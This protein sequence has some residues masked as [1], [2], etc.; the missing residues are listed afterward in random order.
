MNKIYKQEPEYTGSTLDDCLKSDQVVDLL[1]N[2]ITLEEDFS[3][4][5][6]EMLRIIGENAGVDRCYVYEYSDGDYNHRRKIF[7][8]INPETE[9][10]KSPL[11]EKSLSHFPEC[12]RIL[13]ERKPVIIED[14]GQPPSNFSP[15]E[16]AEFRNRGIQSV[17]L[18]G[19]W[20]SS[21]L[22]GFVGLDC[23]I[24]PQK[25]SRS[26]LHTVNCFANLFRL[27]HERTTQKEALLES[28]SLQ[29]QIMDN[30]SVP[31]LLLDLNYHVLAANP[32]KKVNVD[33]PL[34]QLLGT[35]CYNTVCKFGAPP[36]FC[37]VQETMRTKKPSSK[38]FSF[39]PKR[40]IS[41]A[42]PIFDR[43][44]EMQ[45]VLNIDLDITEVTRQKEELKAA[46]EQAQA[47]NHAKSYFLATVSHELRTPLNAV[48]GFTEL[49]QNGGIDE[50]TQEDYL[51]SINFA[52]NAL[53]NLINDVLDLSNL[54]ANQIL[55]APVKNDVAELITRVASVFK[56]KVKEKNIGLFTEVNEVKYPLYVDNLRLRQILLN[57]LGN[58][59]KF[60]SEGKV[61]V[62]ASFK[63]EDDEYGILTIS[64]TDTGI[65]I[66][67]ANQE[68]I[69]EPFVHDSVIRGKSMYEGSGLG[70]TISK[71]LLDKMGGSIHLDSEL[72]KGSTFTI[73]LNQVKYDP[74]ELSAAPREKPKS[75]ADATL[76]KRRML[77]VDDV[78]LN[79]KVLS[80]ML[81]L[82][83][84]E[85][86]LV[87]LPETVPDL[88]RQDNKYD[89]IL[90]DMWM[91]KLSGSELTE[92]IRAEKLTDIPIAA[93]TADTQISE[94]DR[95]LF[96]YILYKPITV[97]SLKQMLRT[98]FPDDPVK[99]ISNENN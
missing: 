92:Q 85:T 6:G 50:K 90:T 20:S 59:I 54:E 55:I 64:V 93:V 72:G 69:F 36:E 65:G 17:L 96:S 74:I 95:N 21:H 84:V 35:C 76:P 61:T 77:L 71:R 48:I 22:Y 40:L 91:P 75:L 45:Y 14:L 16:V 94:K 15:E 18:H 29:K 1:L 58:A 30:I 82:L 53:L 25:I 43:N 3:A 52:G 56:L 2:K 62:K 26:V 42:Q 86:T 81:K 80:A 38:E 39:G 44:G 32:T 27:A 9:S 37:S 78:Q 19:I 49:L 70:L 12:S 10:F 89:M 79:L 67:P 51:H 8:W 88:L 87:D 99:T 28:V 97:D 46:M 66:S 60:T 73:Q 47:A 11:P 83:N 98:V 5:A 4:V 33:T 68:R 13:L 41:T 57:L 7:E 31:I 24:Q 63:P 23:I 34:N